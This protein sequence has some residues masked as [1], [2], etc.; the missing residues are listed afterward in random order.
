[1]VWKNHPA[2]LKSVR[3]DP[4]F[5]RKNLIELALQVH[6]PDFRFLL[7]VSSL[8]LL[9]S[10]LKTAK[11]QDLNHDLE[12]DIGNSQER[13]SKPRSGALRVTSAGEGSLDLGL[14]DQTCKENTL[15]CRTGACWETI[16][17]AS[18]PLFPQITRKSLHI[19]RECVVIPPLDHGQF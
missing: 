2:C 19:L 17:Y 5:V 10:E 4:N 18:Q 11:S 13:R 7:K 12:V 16:S 14:R 8:G 9:I 3:K 6:W 15:K 1:M